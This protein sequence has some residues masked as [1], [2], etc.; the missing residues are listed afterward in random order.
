MTRL[1]YE[2]LRG[3]GAIICKHVSYPKC[4][5]LRASRGQPVLPED[6]GWQFLCGA[7]NH[8]GADAALWRLDEIVELDSTVRSLL[9]ASA[10]MSFERTT[11]ADTW[12]SAEES[13]G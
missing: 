4:P 11:I 10:G 2:E 12:V 6:S 5:I 13:D 1:S 7:P 9:D 3:C 8:S